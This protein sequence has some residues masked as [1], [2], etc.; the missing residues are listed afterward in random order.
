VTEVSKVVS[1]SIS[2]PTLAQTSLTL[3]NASKN[4]PTLTNTYALSGSSNEYTWRLG[5]AN[6][7]N[8]VYVCYATHPSNNNGGSGSSVYI[9]NVHTNETYT[10][11]GTYEIYARG[12]YSLFAHLNGNEFI[13]MFLTGSTDDGIIVKRM[14]LS[15]TNSWTDSFSTTHSIPNSSLYEQWHNQCKPRIRQRDGFTEIIKSYLYATNQHHLSY[16]TYRFDFVLIKYTHSTSSFSI[17]NVTATT[18]I[19]YNNEASNVRDV[20]SLFM[21]PNSNQ[22]VMMYGYT[23]NASNNDG[24]QAYGRLAKFT[25]DYGDGGT[26]SNFLQVG[27]TGSGRNAGNRKYRSLIPLYDSSDNINEVLLWN[28]AHTQNVTQKV[29]LSNLSHSTV[30]YNSDLNVYSTG[31]NDYTQAIT[32]DNIG[33]YYFISYFTNDQKIGLAILDSKATQPTYEYYETSYTYGGSTDAR[34]YSGHNSFV[35]LNSDGGSIDWYI[36]MHWP[37]RPYTIERYNIPLVSVTGVQY[38]GKNKLTVNG[39]NYADTSTVTYYS[40]TYNLGT[41]KTMYVKDVGEYVFKINGTDKYVES[42]VYVSS[43]DLAGATTKPISFDGYNKLT[44]IDAGE[45]AVSNVTLGATKYDMGSASTFYIKDTGTYDL[46]MSGSN[47]FALSSNVVGSIDQNGPTYTPG[48]QWSF[49]NTLA[50]TI[51]D[52]Q[53]DYNTTSLVNASV[54]TNSALVTRH[55]MTTAGAAST[56]YAT[57]GGHTALRIGSSY[58]HILPKAQH[59]EVLYGVDGSNMWKGSKN[60]FMGEWTVEIDVYF[61]GS[62]PTSTGTLLGYYISGANEF[63]QVAG[64]RFVAGFWYTEG[65]STPNQADYHMDK[66]LSADTWYNVKIVNIPSGSGW[67]MRCYINGEFVEGYDAGNGIKID[68]TT[69]NSVRSRDVYGHNNQSSSDMIL[70]RRYSP[71]ANVSNSPVECYVR[72]L[73]FYPGSLVE[74]FVTPSLTFDNYNKLTV[75]NFNSTDIEWPP[76]RPWTTPAT[77]T[78]SDTTGITGSNSGKD[79]TWTI[80]GAAYGNGVYS[81]TCDVAIHNSATNHGPWK[82]FSKTNINYGFVTL[83]T[84]CKV[85]LTMPESIVLS[86]YEF[87]HRRFSIHERMKRIPMEL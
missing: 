30:S 66:D 4:L 21:V 80:S 36:L 46:E 60:M 58:A 19:Y 43:V 55:T 38:D 53:I 10:L 70:G 23:S 37:E 11:S 45:N 29:T 32:V 79:A 71:S 5:H 6:V 54:S 44:L 78:D 81:A 73:K 33:S 51:D 8:N 72:N 28:S 48:I 18:G 69:E 27:T 49:N 40:N 34:R 24:A 25:Y 57:K 47:V 2:S 1:G 31:S 84:T 15:S 83:V 75:S 64:S 41:A 63:I 82:L 85:E 77:T 22:Y 74:P 13:I 67:K 14:T 12:P 3:T 50:P 68:S 16:R 52:T 59:E 20:N 76:P 35:V 7:N 61:D 42:N 39:T 86:S 26:V 87:F 56:Q 17:E 62:V 65:G 9:R